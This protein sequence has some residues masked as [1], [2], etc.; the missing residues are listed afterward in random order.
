M[1]NIL[2]STFSFKSDLHEERQLYV[3][4]LK[5]ALDEIGRMREAQEGDELRLDTNGIRA[6]LES[7][8]REME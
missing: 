6:R 5:D 4:R 8:V 2:Y 3:S 7:I 1:C